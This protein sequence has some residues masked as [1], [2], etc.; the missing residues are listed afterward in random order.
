MM[1]SILAATL[2]SFVLLAGCKEDPEKA[3]NKLFVE[4]V[5]LWNQYQ[6]LPDT[7]PTQYGVRLDLLTQLVKNLDVIVAE[8]AESS[9]AVE[10][11]STGQL[12]Q[13][14]KS[15]IVAEVTRLEQSI[16]AAALMA[17]I[18]P[19]WE[20]Y[21]SL[22]SNDPAHYETRLALLV[23]VKKAASQL[24]KD[25]PL[26]Y[27]SKSTSDILNNSMEYIQ[28]VE[29]QIQC[30]KDKVGC[31]VL[32]ALEVSD[33][34]DHPSA[35]SEALLA[36]AVAQAASGDISGAESTFSM[37]LKATESIPDNFQLAHTL[38]AIARAQAASGDVSGVQSTVSMA[39]KATE[40]ILIEEDRYNALSA[41]AQ[42][43]AASGDIDGALMT[44]KGIS[45]P[46][47]RA[48]VLIGVAKAQVKIGDAAGGIKTAESIPEYYWR[49]IA[50][51]SVA[52]AIFLYGETSSVKPTIS[53]AIKS[54]EFITDMYEHNSALSA[55]AIMQA[56]SGD[57]FGAWSTSNGI[58]Y[59][60]DT[61]VIAAIAKAQTKSGK[62]NDAMKIVDGTSDNSDRDSILVAICEGQVAAGDAAGA[63]KTAERITDI[64]LRAEVVA[65]TK[66]TTGDIDGALNATEDI[67][68]N[69]YRVSTLAA[70]V[71]ALAKTK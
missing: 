64:S 32:L 39:L 60:A 66:A 16:P 43:Q 36:I 50:L 31:I 10:L 61:A 23:E 51:T 40:G 25:F 58:T 37:A 48:Y 2:F 54:S 22:P 65:K 15:E 1:K 34:I 12:K 13:L 38:S 6:A 4:T 47:S 56:A 5:P 7:D 55:I 68:D 70:I 17:K 18:F 33:D 46:Y 52:D 35:R 53:L 49:T 3:A 29:K 11:V 67:N 14:D 45:L 19:L 71:V 9:L 69:H 8:Y 63:I 28:S 42:A 20:Q 24:V 30:E 44:L 62:I 57:V 26:S 21:K 41:V 59:G 27:E